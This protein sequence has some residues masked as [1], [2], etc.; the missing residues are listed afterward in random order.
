MKCF[1]EADVNQHMVDGKPYTQFFLGLLN[2]IG[3]YVQSYEQLAFGMIPYNYGLTKRARSLEKN[4]MISYNIA[5]QIVDKQ[6][7]KLNNG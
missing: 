3:N 5:V 4:I 6:L 1:F 7:Q 2:D